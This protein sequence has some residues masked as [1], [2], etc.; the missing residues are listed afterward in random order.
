VP[1]DLIEV[2]KAMATNCEK[3]HKEMEEEYEDCPGLYH[4]LNVEQ[5]MAE[6]SI[7]KWEQL[8]DVT[9]YTRGYLD[10]V[11]RMVDGVVTALSGESPST[12]PH[13][14]ALGQLGNQ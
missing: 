7:E 9:T 12:S 3:T 5:R 6:I 2:L 10:S 4:R 11:S 1:K 14:Y 13:V 8:S